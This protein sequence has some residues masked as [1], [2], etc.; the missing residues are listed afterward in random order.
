MFESNNPYSPEGESPKPTYQELEQAVSNLNDILR[1]SK[2]RTALLVDWEYKAEKLEEWLDEEGDSL[3]KSQVEEICE[4]FGFDTEITKTITV[5]VE[6]TLEIKA[7]RGFA[8]D[9]LDEGDFT[10]SIE[11]DNY[12]G[13]WRIN[14]ENADITDVSVED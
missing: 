11:K 13:D 14:D 5:S 7:D 3:T 8:F 6:F 12:H 10:V 2:A 4:I 9:D 1:E